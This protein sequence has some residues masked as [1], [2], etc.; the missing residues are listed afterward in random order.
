M[1]YGTFCSGI[2]APSVVWHS[3]GWKPVFFSEISPFQSAVLKQRWPDV[4]NIGD[5]NK[6]HDNP[7]FKNVSVDLILAGTPCQSFS[8]AGLRAG[9]GSPNGNL[10]LQFL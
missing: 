7:T 9:L 1:N 6:A 3:I 4:P 8:I 5:M 2:E 10:A